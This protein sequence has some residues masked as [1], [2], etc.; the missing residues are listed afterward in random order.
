MRAKTKF[1]IMFILVPIVFPIVS[2]FV[3]LYYKIIPAIAI[4]FLG[5]VVYAFVVLK[6]G[7]KTTL[8]FIE[9]RHA[10]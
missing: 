2:F 7:T 3:G 1:I 5:T 6:Y 10:T 9:A 8:E 4:I